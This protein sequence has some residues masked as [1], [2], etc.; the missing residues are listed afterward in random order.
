MKICFL[1]GSPDI[2]GGTYV[3]FQHALFLQKK[4]NCQVDIVAIFPK[5]KENT[6]WHP[7]AQQYLNFIS[8]EEADTKEYNVTIATW[9]KTVFEIPR[10]KTERYIYFVQSIES[11]FYPEDEIPL[12]ALVDSTY[13]LNIPVIT[14]ASWIRNYLFTNYNSD[15][16]LVLN[17]IRKD[18]YKPYGECINS[19]KEGL[20]VLVEGPVNVSF[21]NVP[22]TIELCKKSKAHEIWLLTSSEISSFTNVDRVF[23]RVPITK[24]ASIYRSCDVVVKLSYIEGMFGPPLEMFHCGGTAIVYNVTG[25]DEYIRHDI[26]SLVALKD[27]ENA[28]VEYLQLLQHNKSKL[29]DLKYEAL[30]TALN[31]PDWN[32]SSATFFSAIKDIVQQNH[33]LDQPLLF[34]R[35]KEN[36][37]IYVEHENIKKTKTT[38]TN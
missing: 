12:R 31:W 38:S 4:C 13:N 7:E 30:K 24:T 2:S 26:N 17:G 37:S 16:W 22:K 8:F 35:I 19:N 11:W 33:K 3:I 6:N 34:D 27:D 14:E 20:R 28:V 1:I 21:K 18:I 15:S 10:I 29:S 5:T 25:H 32:Q 9:W 36:F 23:S